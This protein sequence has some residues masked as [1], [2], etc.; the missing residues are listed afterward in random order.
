MR[1]EA[2]SETYNRVLFL[3]GKHGVGKSTV[4]REF[5]KQGWRHMSM[6][7]IGRIVRRGQVPRGYLTSFLARMAAHR[8]NN[9]IA[10]D[11]LQETVAQIRAFQAEGPLVV[12]GFP[13]TPAHIHALP[14][15]SSAEGHPLYLVYLS[16]DEDERRRRLYH[17]AETTRRKWDFDTVGSERDSM[18]EK[19]FNEAHERGM[20]VLRIGSDGTAAS[21][22]RRIMSNVEGLDEV[23][24]E[25]RDFDF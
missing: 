8:P 25:F 3:I 10:G 23:E 7:E 16:C 6:G 13:A 4:G 15:F 2:S 11:L 5:E 19:V 1:A 20:A 17:R 12:D 9:P 24:R 22:V 18:L 14:E 21:T